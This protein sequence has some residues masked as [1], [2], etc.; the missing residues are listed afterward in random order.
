MNERSRWKSLNEIHARQKNT[1]WPD[2]MKNRAL[3]DSFL[4]KGSSEATV[5]QRIGIALFG[6][7]FFCP[8]MLI[9]RFGCLEPGPA[10]FRTLMFLLALPWIAIGCRLLWNSLRY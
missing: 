10:L 6:L 2:L 7:L 8:A 9:V 3:V 4:W 1:V 5:V